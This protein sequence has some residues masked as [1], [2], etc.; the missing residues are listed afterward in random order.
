MK[1]IEQDFE[2]NFGE[3]SLKITARNY[4]S[5]RLRFGVDDAS[6][7]GRDFGYAQTS[8][9]L[10]QLAIGLNKVADEI[11]NDSDFKK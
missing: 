2:I 5:Y 7:G 10:R 6:F 3:Y 1:R 11:E 9:E 4:Q 8:D